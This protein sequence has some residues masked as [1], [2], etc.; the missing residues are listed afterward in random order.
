VVV[1]VAVVVVA[2]VENTT[3]TSTAVAEDVEVDAGAARMSKA[4]HHLLLRMEE[5]L[6]SICNGV[7]ND[8]T[9]NRMAPI[10]S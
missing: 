4:L 6:M 3:R 5:D 1:V 8:L 7:C 2:D 9:E 10:M